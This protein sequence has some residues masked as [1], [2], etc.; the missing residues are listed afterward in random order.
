MARDERTPLLQH[1]SEEEADEREVLRLRDSDPENPRAWPRWRKLMNV[2]VIA[3][4]ASKS[5]F[6]I[7]YVSANEGF[8][9]F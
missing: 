2:G 8:P 9:Q 5:N 3:M 1:H 4:M 7:L 6:Q